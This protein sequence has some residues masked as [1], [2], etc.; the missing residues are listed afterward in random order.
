MRKKL[1]M[2][3]TKDFMLANFRL[4]CFVIILRQ[5][6]FIIGWKC[7]EKYMIQT[8]IK[9]VLPKLRLE[10]KSILLELLKPLLILFVEKRKKNLLLLLETVEMLLLLET[11]AM[12]LLLDTVVLQR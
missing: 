9:Y 4:K 10:Q 2:H 5:G 11:V 12:L 1:L 6:V 3:V 8:L 7:L